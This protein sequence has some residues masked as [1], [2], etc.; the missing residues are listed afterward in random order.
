LVF[1]SHMDDTTAYHFSLG[2][3]SDAT[4]LVGLGAVLGIYTALG[5]FLC[6]ALDTTGAQRL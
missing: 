4:R 1:G 6:S 5:L 3:V 2:W